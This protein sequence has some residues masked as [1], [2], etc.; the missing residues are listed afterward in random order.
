MFLA[1]AL[2]S[3]HLFRVAPC[4]DRP[5]PQGGTTKETYLDSR[6]QSVVDCMSSNGPA[7]YGQ[8]KGPAP[9]IVPRAGPITKG[10]FVVLAHPLSG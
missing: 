10:E 9:G 1:D 8:K 7:F 5:D 4:D 6:D 2:L 3:D